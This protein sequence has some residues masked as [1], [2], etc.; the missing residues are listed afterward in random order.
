M[1]NHLQELHELLQPVVDEHGDAPPEVLAAALD[2]RLAEL[3]AAG[4][5]WPRPD[6]ERVRELRRRVFEVAVGVLSRPE[7]PNA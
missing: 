6:P 2:A 1:R 4:V 5:P 3:R 7:E